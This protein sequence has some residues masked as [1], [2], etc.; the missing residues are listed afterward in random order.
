MYKIAIKRT[1]VQRPIGRVELRGTSKADYF[2][3]FF[4]SVSP[5]DPSLR[6][7]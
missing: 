1:I 3:F 4:L 6:S 5:R 7:G 2:L